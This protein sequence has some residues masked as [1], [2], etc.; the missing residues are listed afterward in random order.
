MGDMKKRHI[1]LAVV[2]GAGIAILILL[3]S[4]DLPSLWG[5]VCDAFT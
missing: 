5:K 3:F 4:L 2:A 1:A